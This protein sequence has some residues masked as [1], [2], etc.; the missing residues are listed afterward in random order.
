MDPYLI[1]DAFAKPLSSRVIFTAYLTCVTPDS[2]SVIDYFVCS[3]E[4]DRLVS[5]IEGRPEIEICAHLA[6]SLHISTREVGEDALVFVS[7]PSMPSDPLPGPR[8]E[9]PAWNSV[10]LC[11]TLGESVC[12]ETPGFTVGGEQRTRA[13]SHLESAFFATTFPYADRVGRPF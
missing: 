2:Q 5:M 7:P 9:P 3:C 1:S 10:E 6:M 12:S 8:R 4:F 11:L 13:Q